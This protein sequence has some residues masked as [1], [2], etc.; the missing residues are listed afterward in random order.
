VASLTRPTAPASRETGSGAWAGCRS[1]FMR[2]SPRFKVL[3]LA[4]L[5]AAGVLA[6]G[7]CGGT[8]SHPAATAHT[9][10]AASGA[11]A[12]STSTSSPT[13]TSTP[14]VGGSSSGSAH[15]TTS[16][17]GGGTF[18]GGTCTTAG[19]NL[20][21]TIGR[22]HQG[23]YFSIVVAAPAAPGPVSGGLIQWGDSTNPIAIGATTSTIT[24]DAGLRSGSFAGTAVIASRLQTAPGGGT[25][26]CD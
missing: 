10:P 24:F 11:S 2:S 26:A 5:A 13:R 1:R 6:L 23:S 9:T 21:V 8:S 4:T 3:R 18:S 7:A 19:G 17:P 14:A 16:G 25:F 20:Y 15:A 22:A 12:G